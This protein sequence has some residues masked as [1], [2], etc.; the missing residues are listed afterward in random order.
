MTQ[1]Q[2]ILLVLMGAAMVLFISQALRADLVAL[3][4]LIAMS[5]TQV[6]SP[7]E[8][9]SG[10]SRSAVITVMSLF[11]LTN[12]L[13]RTGATRQLGVGLLRLAGGGATRL[14]ALV[15]V[16][17][18]LLSLF[19]NNIAAGAV[20]LPIVMGLTG[21]SKICPSKLLMPL[22]F[23][24]ILG[25]M[26]TLFT[27]S[28]ILVS[29]ALRDDGLSAFGV[30]DFAPTG[31]V[32]A[33]AGTLFMVLIG[34]RL[35][36][37]RHPLEH[38]SRVRVLRQELS[39]LYQLRE[40]LWEL[41]VEPRSPVAGSTLARSD[42]GERLGLSVLAIVHNGHVALAPKPDH[43]LY[44]NDILLIAGREERVAKLTER[45]LNLLMD[46]AWQGDLSS[47]KIGMFEVLVAP[48]SA[49]VGR[50][51][52]Q[53]HFREKYGLSVVALWREGRPFRTDVGDMPLRFGDALLVHGELD[54]ARVLQAEPDYLV[55]LPEG[56]QA[57]RPA[58]APLAVGIMA[59][60]VLVAAV[61]WLPVA[62][63]MLAGALLAV[64]TGCLTMDEA[65][66]AIEWRVVFLI[67]GMLPLGLAMA[68]SGT[69]ALLGQLVLQTLGGY[70]PMV[71]LAGFYALT[72][73]LT[74]VMSGQATAVVVAPIAL[75]AAR[76]MGVNPYTFA[77]AVALASSTAFI[78]PISHPVN[79]LVMGPGGY[80]FRDFIKVG[81]P[82]TLVTGAAALAALP[83]FW[84]LAK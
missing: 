78:M 21:Q 42:I 81:L 18:G 34:W 26:A 29:T 31:G 55:L 72:V 54:K 49:V 27:T 51:I 80:T 58:K 8:A 48:R 71:I 15:I 37:D 23:G 83:I 4:L 20:L 12:A 79:I 47:D 76:A 41:R 3:L 75:A 38:I 17:A 33:L 16:A 61:G 9:F 43:I 22:A 39:E 10:F 7:Q 45:G 77:M 35:L 70:G 30:L 84:P 60:S 57:Q 59:L 74:Q 50:T 25:G 73:G 28:N 53:I 24:T 46:V 36:P 40:R 5:V 82:M 62:E 64:I 19:M 14:V 1:P 63:A 67:A 66:H 11:I 44:V 6:L 65:Y 2:I 56:Y 69:A 13:H 68:K 32:V 52:K